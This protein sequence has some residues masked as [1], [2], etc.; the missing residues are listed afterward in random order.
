MDASTYGVCLQRRRRSRASPLTGPVG[1][2]CTAL[3][4][5]QGTAPAEPKVQWHLR[6]GSAAQLDTVGQ[7][8]RASGG[9]RHELVTLILLS[10]HGRRVCYANG[11][12]FFGQEC[13][14]CSASKH[15]HLKCDSSLESAPHR[16][17]A[18]AQ[19][20]GHRRE[21]AS[22]IVDGARKKR[23]RHSKSLSPCPDDSTL[24]STK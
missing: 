14:H 1:R 17:R 13:L 12:F 10:C 18:R 7:R 20:D 21:E 2:T 24:D 5:V 6:S 16:L 4:D 9:H 15:V 8:S 19:R 23:H 3:R 22:V 11:V